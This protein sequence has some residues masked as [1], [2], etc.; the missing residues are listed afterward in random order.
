[1]PQNF[2][3]KLSNH[4]SCLEPQETNIEQ[5]W[6]TKR[7]III[8]TA[9]KNIPKKERNRKSH[10]LSQKA[11]EIA[12]DRRYAKKQKDHSKL[13]NLNRAYRYISITYRCVSTNYKILFS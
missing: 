3:I 8:A 10:W 1:M 6:Q 4:F 11:I 13:N 9:E 5:L 7:D 2:A 12:E